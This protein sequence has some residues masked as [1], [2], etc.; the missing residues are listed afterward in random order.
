MTSNERMREPFHQMKSVY[1][2]WSSG[3]DVK[4]GQ[5]S[6]FGRDKRWNEKDI[7]TFLLDCDNQTI[8][9]QNKRINWC[10]AFHIDLSL[11]PFPWKFLTIIKGCQLRLENHS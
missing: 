5:S 3:Y 7:L 9:F 10:H 4:S 6:G 1:G 2:V 8:I 11:C